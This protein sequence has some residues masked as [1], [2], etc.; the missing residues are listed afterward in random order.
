MTELFD[1]SMA[2]HRQKGL[3]D[4]EEVIRALEETLREQIRIRTGSYLERDLSRYNPRRI[5]HV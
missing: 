5:G 4:N 3:I 1:K 2:G